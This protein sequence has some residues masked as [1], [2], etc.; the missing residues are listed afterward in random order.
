MKTITITEQ[1]KMTV[2]E[3]K[4][5]MPYSLMADGMIIAIVSNDA[6]IEIE[7]IPEYLLTGKVICPNCKFKVDLPKKDN[8][9]PFFS[10]QHP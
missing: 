8:A 5:A 4:D 6:P 7:L 2:S 9:A 10:I 3:I 1:K